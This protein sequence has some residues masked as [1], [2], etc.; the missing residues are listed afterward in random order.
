MPS[1]TMFEEK[2][3]TFESEIQEAVAECKGMGAELCIAVGLSTLKHKL[4]VKAKKHMLPPNKL[5]LY[6][7]LLSDAI[8]LESK[9][10]TAVAAREYKNAEV[11]QDLL[12]EKKKEIEDAKQK[13][14][15]ASTTTNTSQTSDFYDQKLW[16]FEGAWEFE[17]AMIVLLR[18]Y[19]SL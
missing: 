13:L 3:S 5:M 14:R 15:L 1:Y 10:K 2:I 19:G 4:L 8:I 11:K 9:M 12:K 6:R 18:H 7:I 17:S 16:E